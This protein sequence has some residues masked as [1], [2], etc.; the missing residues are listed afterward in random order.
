MAAAPRRRARKRMPA[1]T[2]ALAIAYHGMGGDEAL[3]EWARANPEKFYVFP[4]TTDLGAH[5]AVF[6]IY[7]E[8][9]G[10]PLLSVGMTPTDS[11]SAVSVAGNLLSLAVRAGD[12][13]ALPVNADDETMPALLW[14]DLIVTTP[15]PELCKLY[16]GLMRVM[17]YGAQ[18][19]PPGG[20]IE[21]SLGGQPVV[22]EVAP[23][24]FDTAV[25]ALADG[26]AAT[27]QAAGATATAAAEV[28]TAQASD[29]GNFAA[30][31]SSA[32]AS[33]DGAASAASASAS[34]AAD[35][36]SLAGTSATG[37]AVSAASAV[38][39]ASVAN[40]L[41]GNA[42]LITPRSIVDGNLNP[43]FDANRKLAFAVKVSGQTWIANPL[44]PAGV[45][46]A[47]ALDF[48]TQSL[49]PPI[50]FVGSASSLSGYAQP[51][52]DKNRKISG[53]WL[54]S[55]QF[56]FALPPVFPAGAIGYA[57]LDPAVTGLFPPVNVMRVATDASGYFQPVYDTNRKVAGGWLTTGQYKFNLMPSLPTG[58]ILEARSRSTV[59]A[60]NG[61]ARDNAAYIVSSFVDGS[62]YRQA[63]LINRITGAILWKTVGNSNKTFAEITW[64][65]SYIRYLDDIS[66][67]AT[68]MYTP[69]STGDNPCPFEPV[70]RIACW[71]DSLTAGSSSFADG[72]AGPYPTQLAVML[73]R[74]VNNF[75]ASSQTSSEIIARQGAVPATVVASGGQLNASGATSLTSISGR[76]LINI[77]DNNVNG[78]HGVSTLDGTIGGVHGTLSATASN[79]TSTYSFT[80]TN[81]GSVVVIP[82]NTQFIPD[83]AA[84]YRN[85]IS[86]FIM[87]RNDPA[88]QPLEDNI[89]S[90]I[91]YLAAYTKRFI[92]G[93]ILTYVTDVVGTSAYNNIVAINNATADA[94]PH[95]YVELRSPPNS[96]ELSWLFSRFS[97]TPS[98]QDLVD[99]TAD[100]IPHGL[101]ISDG[102]HLN[103][104]GYGLWAYRIYNF[105]ASKGW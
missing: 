87:G 48:T 81:A 101:R 52:Y 44:F 45:I 78:V 42:A 19:T 94:Y 91:K 83:Y 64:D 33:A 93:G 79:N 41:V 4:E 16:G 82:D 50:S 13:D 34:G 23:S 80:R 43:I 12:I 77:A 68:E 100:T 61:G 11:G 99:I 49:I 37:A 1:I 25:L 24:G 21:V 54:T 18:I 38:G 51:V 26:Y 67:V 105:L 14:F 74:A 65:G 20:T 47:G 89:A 17:P 92:V 46:P 58:Q 104:I 27:A 62:G 97:Y 30:A 7:G 85:D 86:I 98:S 76:L 32:A 70:T 95:N 8:R 35:S 3:T 5:S 22:V 96:S 39:A 59:Q 66:G 75:G 69:I 9:N 84:I 57:A 36:A 15:S 103:S 55:G 102:L 29:A 60:D 72:G 40:L 73:G 90:A 88:F 56:K 2:E 71:G 10:A 63:R 28:A 6:T 53:G 31:A